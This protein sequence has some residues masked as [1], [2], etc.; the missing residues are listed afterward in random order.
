ML[1]VTAN[2]QREL[3]EAGPAVESRQREKEQ[4]ILPADIDD[5]LPLVWVVSAFDQ[6]KCTA[7]A[8]EPFSDSIATGQLV[9]RWEPATL[10]KELD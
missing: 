4:Q 1:D 8:S 9:F 5:V 2:R 7:Q 3:A 6:P 10:L